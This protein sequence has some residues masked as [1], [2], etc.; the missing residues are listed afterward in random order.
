MYLISSCLFLDFLLTYT[1]NSWVSVFLF[2]GFLLIM[3]YICHI[4]NINISFL[5]WLF[6]GFVSFMIFDG[7]ISPFPILH[8]LS[9]FYHLGSFYFLCSWFVPFLNSFFFS[10]PSILFRFILVIIWPI[11]G[12]GSMSFVC[13]SSLYFLFNNHLWFTI[14]PPSLLIIFTTFVLVIIYLLKYIIS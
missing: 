1:T 4:D 7:I 11:S 5:Y 9:V 13:Q 14:L 8:Y 6:T 10:F 3:S 2:N 12:V